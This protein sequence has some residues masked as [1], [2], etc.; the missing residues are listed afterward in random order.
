MKIKLTPQELY[1]LSELLKQD[2]N[3]IADLNKNGILDI[4]KSRAFLIKAE[5]KSLTSEPK[6][7]KQDIVSQLARKYQI[8]VS[9][10]EVIIYSKTIN[11]PRSC[12]RCES[13]IS[14]YKYI[15]NEGICDNCKIT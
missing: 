15:K 8:S 9:S 6:Q 5:Y 1:E 2:V 11:K 12:R 4:A 13:K 10:I 7:L 3:V 14:K